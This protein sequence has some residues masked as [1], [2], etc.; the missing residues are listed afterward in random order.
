[1]K[2]SKPFK[3]KQTLKNLR[4]LR[5]KGYTYHSL[6]FL[7]GVDFSTVYYHV[8]DIHPKETISFSIPRIFSLLGLG[9]IEISEI[10]ASL[11]IRTREKS[12]REYFDELRYPNIKRALGRVT[13]TP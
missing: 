5:E 7:Y 13:L 12:Y 10:I 8:R 4:S 3:D 2:Q 9:T 11:G 1:M 6:A